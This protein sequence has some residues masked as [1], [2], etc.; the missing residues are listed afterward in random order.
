MTL[1]TSRESILRKRKRG[2]EGAKTMKK[3]YKDWHENS[4]LEALTR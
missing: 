3:D 1:P 2:S 4:F